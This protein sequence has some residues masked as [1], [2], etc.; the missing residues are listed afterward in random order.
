MMDK[1]PLVS[2]IIP[3]YNGSNYMREA[4]ESALHQTYENVEVIVVNDGST[5]N[6]ITEKIA[7]SYGNKIRYFYKEN[8]G[9]STALNLGIKNMKGEYF[10]WLSHDD[11]YYPNKIEVQINYLQKNNLLNKKV[12]TYTNYDVINE[13]SD[14]TNIMHFEKFK[15]NLYPE[16]AIL[17]GLASGTSL[18]IPKSA[19]DEYGLFDE[20]YRCIQDYLLFFKFMNDYQYIF[21]PNVVTNSTR[22]HSKQVTNCNPKVIQENNFLWTY[23]QKEFSNARKIKLNGSLYKFYSG[24]YN[25]LNTIVLYPEAIDYSKKQMQKE[26]EKYYKKII[27]AYQL[28]S[29]QFVNSIYNAYNKILRSKNAYLGNPD[30]VNDS[31]I[32]NDVIDEL[33]LKCVLEI[34]INEFNNLPSDI[35]EI[36]KNLE[37]DF[38]GDTIIKLTTK[39][40]IKAL[41]LEGGWKLVYYNMRRK[42][43]NIIH[44]NFVLKVLLKIIKIIRKIVFF[45]PKIIIRF[46]LNS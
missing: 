22:V 28:N 46:I 33:G 16:Y 21:I 1:M 40:K 11:R 2:I 23:M 19:F 27:E 3:V 4:I 42:F 9:V 44:N 14:V 20:N 29:T 39:Q 17:H 13:K 36:S 6:G 45:I 12:I 24:M 5:D 8:G 30:I 37:T 34:V 43:V 31:D 26:I 41:K 7:K 10:S 35:L 32:L 25:Y 15:P 18:L 38:N